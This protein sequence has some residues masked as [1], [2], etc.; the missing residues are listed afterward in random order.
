MKLSSSL[1]RLAL[2]ATL[3]GLS[4]G[5]LAQGACERYRAELTQLNRSGAATR[6]AEIAAQRQR[7]EI[8]RLANYYR[9]I[10]CEQASIF[11][12]APAE[13][14]AIASRIRALQASYGSVADQGGLDPAA[15]DARRRQLQAAIAR[16]CDAPTP[17]PVASPPTEATARGGGRLVCV[18]TC[19]G[20]FFPIETE[21][22]G[23]RSTE[24]LCQAL[25]PNAETAVYRAPR[26]GSIE[27]AVS[28]RGRS[29]MQL[30]N[31]LKYQKGTDPSCSCRKPGQ[32]WAEA[33]QKADRLIERE[34]SDVVVTAAMAERLSRPRIA[35]PQSRRLKS[36]DA[37][38][39]VAA[40]NTGTPTTIAPSASGRADVDVTG[41]VASGPGTPQRPRIIAPDI[42]PIPKPE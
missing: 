32:S 22:R 6:G 5:A 36:G 16:T 7:N 35:G 13:C 19:D 14:G 9:G 38:Q 27:D 41:S 39:V 18:R 20:Y 42:V 24:E 33:L 31:A 26:D 11:F 21:P 37:A 29:Y 23:R 40:T 34:K 1:R 8:V 17:P 25:C 2:L 10:G 28:D 12:Q 3:T 4:T 30:A 15:I